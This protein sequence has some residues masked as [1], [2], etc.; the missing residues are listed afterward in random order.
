MTFFKKY[1]WLV[2]MSSNFDWVFCM[3]KFRFLFIFIIM[4]SVNMLKVISFY[5][6]QI[7]TYYRNEDSKAPKHPAKIEN[8]KSYNFLPLSAGVS[9]L[10]NQ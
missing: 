5:M 6:Y 2:F 7:F 10:L 4:F 8:F 1:V 3:F 9:L